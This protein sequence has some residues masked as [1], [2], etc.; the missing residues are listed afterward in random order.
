MDKIKTKLTVIVPAY[1]EEKN[2]ALLLRSLLS[3]VDANE[4]DLDTSLYQILVVDNN[5]S[6]DTRKIVEKFIEKGKARRI[7]IISEK[8]KGVI[9]ARIKGVNFVLNNHGHFSKTEYLAFCDADVIAPEKW[10]DSI[11]SNFEKTNSDVLSYVGAFPL[12]FWRNVP[13][14]AKRY[15]DDI[16]TIFFDDKTIEWLGV[17]GEEFKFTKKI[18]SDFVRP[19]SGGFYAIRTNTYIKTGGYTREFVDDNKKIEVDGPTWRLYF[20][21][22]LNKVKISYIDNICLECSPRRLLGDPYKFFKIQTYDQLSDLEDYRDVPKKEYKRVDNL[23]AKIDLGPVQ[24]YIIEYYI[25]LPCVNRLESIKENER[26]FGYLGKE[27]ESKVRS[28]WKSHLNPRGQDIFL[29]C[30]RLTDKYFE[31]LLKIIPKQIA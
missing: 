30:K 3:Q 27:I 19:P 29:F 20:K 14:L 22:R 1:N 15:L 6:D 11:L 21:L 26:Y 5:S 8:D 16:G 24:R 10:I 13:L 4:E 18:F 25:L 31:K 2:I 9:S 17:K 12:K 28:W 23:A 7:E